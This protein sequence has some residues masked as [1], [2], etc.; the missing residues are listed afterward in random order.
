ML[1]GLKIVEIAEGISGPLAALRLSEL[2]ARQC[3]RLG[4]YFRERFP[5]LKA[6]ML[7]RLLSISIAASGRSLWAKPHAARRIDASFSALMY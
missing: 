3:E 4:E 2:G 5:L 6:V 7:P 1:D